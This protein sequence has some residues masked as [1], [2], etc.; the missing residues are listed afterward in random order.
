MLDPNCENIP[1]ETIMGK[2]CWD[3]ATTAKVAGVCKNTV[4]H[5]AKMTAEGRLDMPV[6]RNPVRGSKIWVP[7]KEFKEW[8]DYYQG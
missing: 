4:V 8:F 3:A 7:V 2:K 6:V 1:T 5:W